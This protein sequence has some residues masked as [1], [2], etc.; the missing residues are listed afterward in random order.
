MERAVLFLV[1][2]GAPLLCYKH[3]LT[4]F[5]SLARA[6][7]Y[8]DAYVTEAVGLQSAVVYLFGVVTMFLISVLLSRHGLDLYILQLKCLKK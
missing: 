5:L 1:V 7:L 6:R 4:G 3:I 8:N 2:E